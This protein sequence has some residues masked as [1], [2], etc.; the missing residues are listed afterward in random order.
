MPFPSYTRK[1]TTP[2]K[3]ENRGSSSSSSS[4]TTKSNC[5][6][7]RKKLPTQSIQ[8]NDNKAEYEGDVIDNRPQLD[9][10][11]DEGDSEPL[12]ISSILLELVEKGKVRK[13]AD[14]V[15][16]NNKKYKRLLKQQ[17]DQEEC[18]D[19]YGQDLNREVDLAASDAL[20]QHYSRLG[21]DRGL[22]ELK[23]VAACF[24]VSNDSEDEVEEEQNSSAVEE[25]GGG[26]SFDN[27]GGDES[28]WTDGLGELDTSPADLP[29]HNATQSSTTT[30][31]LKLDISCL[32]KRNGPSPTNAT[33]DLSSYTEDPNPA[34]LYVQDEDDLPS[35]DNG[36]AEKMCNCCNTN[37]PINKFMRREWNKINESRECMEC[38]LTRSVLITK[39][40]LMS[41]EKEIGQSPTNVDPPHKS[42]PRQLL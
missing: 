27:V 8:A 37:L 39:P 28:N 4:T 23:E 1:R 24:E 25:D 42:Y 12:C 19:G 34:D 2:T 10:D 16:I 36:K 13:L 26:I 20:Y 18:V 31:T 17:E 21:D 11:P 29:S 33:A 3:A 15:G 35:F 22:V 40:I 32:G 5:S 30:T 38:A 14:Y 41:C 7:K 6:S 9:T